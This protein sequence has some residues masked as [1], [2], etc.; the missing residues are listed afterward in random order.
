M[1]YRFIIMKYDLQLVIFRRSG[2]SKLFLE[3]VGMIL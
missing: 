3:Y 2:I 1:P